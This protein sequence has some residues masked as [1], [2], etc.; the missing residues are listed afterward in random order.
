MK[1]KIGLALGGGGA[2]G[3]AHLGAWQSLWELGVEFHC[4]AGTSIGAIAGAIIAAGRVDEALKWCAESDWKK[5]PKLFMETQFTAKA[6]TKKSSLRKSSEQR[7]SQSCQRPLPRLRRTST[8][9]KESSCKTETFFR[10][11]AR[12]CRFQA[13][14][15][16]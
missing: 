5:L 11:C 15:V 2:R 16:P 9:A 14:S 4:I 1:C 8:L 7:P 12:R 13:C 10:L 3:I 6:L